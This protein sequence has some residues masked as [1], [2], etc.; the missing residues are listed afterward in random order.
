MTQGIDRDRVSEVEGAAS[1]N[2]VSRGFQP[3]RSLA[4][5]PTLCTLGN[6]IAGFAAMQYATK[7]P[8]TTVGFGWTP[9]GF[10]AALV[11][12]GLV[13]DA[14]D[15][16]IARLMRA[17]S[18]IGAEVDS[19]ADMVTFGVAPAFL[20]ISLLRNSLALDGFIIGPWADD[21]LGKAIWTSA[22]V[23]VCCAALRLAKFNLGFD[24][25]DEAKMTFHGLPSPGAAGLICA[26]VILH[27][28]LVRQYG[29]DEQAL[30]R[31]MGAAMPLLLLGTAIGMISSIPYV[32]FT[33]R[34][35]RGT[36]SFRYVARIAII[37]VALIWFLQEAL[38]IAFAV[39]VGLS[40]AV[41]LVR[42]IRG[43][44]GNR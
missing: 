32:H 41:W 11:F 12:L 38:A 14:I 36:K 40:P 35:L 29:V 16:S 3:A 34:F 9:L 27:Q 42:V 5:L 20:A 39:Y 23:Y 19:L 2:G 4:V 28:H 43:R 37:M 25:S 13:L 31:I 15:G 22:A 17:S 30:G 33:N 7:D 44:F 6:L 1:K 21:I 18:E 26:L 8:S 24:E 10:A